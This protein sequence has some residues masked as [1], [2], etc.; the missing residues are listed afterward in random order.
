MALSARENINGNTPQDLAK[1]NNKFMNIWK[2][3]FVSLDYSDTNKRT[4]Q[5]INT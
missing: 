4:Q 3:L 1:I 5:R 2:T